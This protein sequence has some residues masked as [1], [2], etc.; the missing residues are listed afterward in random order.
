VPPRREAEGGLAVPPRR[1]DVALLS[2][3]RAAAAQLEHT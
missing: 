1:K 3:P 2:S